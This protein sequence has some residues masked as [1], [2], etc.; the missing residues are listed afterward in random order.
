[1][2]HQEIK[3]QCV[4]VLYKRCPE[5]SETLLSLAE[6]CQHHKM[7]AHCLAVIVYDNSPDVQAIP[8]DLSGFVSFEY[9]HDAT[10]GGLVTAYNTALS[11]A[12]RQGRDWLLLLDQDTT[13]NPD[14]ISE[15]VT[16]GPSL[17]ESV[18]AMVPALTQKGKML[19]PQRIG[20]FRNHEITPQ[21]SGV[22]QFAVTALNSAACLRVSCVQ[23][24]GGFPLD[25]WL[26]YLDHVMFSRLHRTGDRVFILNVVMEHRLSL[27]NLEAEMGIG[28]YNNVLSAEWRFVF[29]TKWGGGQVFHRMRL[30]RRA[31]NYAR[32]YRNKDY[33][34][35]TFRAIFTRERRVL[36]A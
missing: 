29:E 26:D 12:Q 30:L 21:A 2:M 25:Y 18:F 13:L 36:N 14:L 15:L 31:V 17:P 24:A 3:I 35:H 27:E 9:I 6:L 34:L 28:R 33:A 19:S 16:T 32:K 10:N 4:V 8:F 20:R 5:E 22:Q 1:M 11:R 7:L 23:A